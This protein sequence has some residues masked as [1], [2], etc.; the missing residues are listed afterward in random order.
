MSIEERAF[1]LEERG[2]QLIGVEALHVARHVGAAFARREHERLDG[3]VHGLGV[4]G[5]GDEAE[6]H[7]YASDALQAADERLRV[8]VTCDHV[9]RRRPRTSEPDR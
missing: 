4:V 9:A 5:H 1:A 2:E 3:R 6:E 7:G 8:E